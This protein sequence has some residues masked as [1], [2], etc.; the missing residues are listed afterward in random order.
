M[1]PRCTSIR[2]IARRSRGPVRAVRAAL[3][4]VF[5]LALMAFAAGPPASAQEPQPLPAPRQSHAPV[6]VGRSQP[7]QE[8][9]RTLMDAYQL[10]AAGRATQAIAQLERLH[11][12]YP[13]DLR[14]IVALADAY[15]RGGEP[16]KAVEVLQGEIAHAGTRE[17]DLWTHMAMAYQLAGMGADATETL[18]AAVQLQPDWLGRMEDQF[19][20]VATDS[21]SGPAAL[22]RLRS[23]AVEK[24]APTVWREALAHVLV[25]TGGFDEAVG[26]VASLDR[27]KRGQGRELAELAQAVAR[28]GDPAVALAVYDSLLAHEPERGVAEEAGFER[29]QLLERLKR[30]AEAMAAYETLAQ[31]FPRGP[32]AM[33]AR[34][35]AASLRRGPLR[36]TAGARATYQQVL[37]EA[38]AE[39]S[40]RSGKA[41]R[42][43]ALL[44]LGECALLDGAFPEAESTFTVLER[45]AVQTSS[46]E[47]A[48]FERAELLF[49][50]GRFADAEEAYYQLTDHYPNGEW[51]NDALARALLL[52]E[53]GTT[54]G[55]SLEAYAGVLYRKRVGAMEDALRLCREALRDTVHVEMRAYLRL[56]EIRITAGLG[57]WTDVDAALALLLEQDPGSRVAPGALYEVAG[58]GEAAPDRRERALELYEQVIL[59]YPNSLEARQA[60]GRLQALRAGTEQS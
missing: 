53:F 21:T 12:R 19:E 7:R 16:L 41:L 56:E 47:R 3:P 27:E 4:L 51:V 26:L 49:Y 38:S 33:Q 9:E 29:G 24:G 5:L 15:A 40:G 10:L 22:D 52:G 36:D 37:A 55:M 43:E 60:R 58:W 46:K 48:A 44:G 34:L 20:I 18:L 32:L 57:L 30:P 50:S 25:V 17:P 11:A 2:E 59:R 8:I 14:V 54:A 45:E 35:R 23:R 6:P 1:M 39:S 28:R 31:D 13:S 42:E